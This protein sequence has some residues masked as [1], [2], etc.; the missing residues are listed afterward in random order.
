LAIRWLSEAFTFRDKEENM[1]RRHAFY[2]FFFGLFGLIFASSVHGADGQGVVAYE[3]IL[4]NRWEMT[5]AQFTEYEKTLMG[6]QVRWSGRL[7]DVT[8][9]Q[10]WFFSP[11]S[12]TARITVAG[13]EPSVLCDVSRDVALRLQ[14]NASYSFSGTIK[15]IDSFLRISVV[16]EDV[17]FD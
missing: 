8:I 13:Y 11:P 5:E 6:Q 16:L 17:T 12:Y 3:Q 1:L 9:E 2:L 14:R 15:S 7:S 4:K 10:P